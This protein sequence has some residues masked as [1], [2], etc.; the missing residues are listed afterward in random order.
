M[1]IDRTSLAGKKDP[2]GFRWGVSLPNP[3]E[4]ICVKRDDCIFPL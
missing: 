1:P 3:G 2:W 4:E